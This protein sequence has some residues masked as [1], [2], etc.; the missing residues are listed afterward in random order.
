M[1]Q[2]ERDFLSHIAQMTNLKEYITKCSVGANVHQAYNDAVEALVSFRS[3]HIQIAARFIIHPSKCSRLLPHMDSSGTDTG[4]SN[5]PN[6]HGTGGTE[7]MS[8]LK[9]TRDETRN[10]VFLPLEE[11]Q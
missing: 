4:V 5:P 1:P 9:K 7:F 3:V 6:L 8:F 2:E 10:A 11:G